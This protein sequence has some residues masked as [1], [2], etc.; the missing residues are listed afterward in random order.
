ME[1]D[2]FSAFEDFGVVDSVKIIPSHKSG[3]SKGFGF[4]EMPDEPSDLKAIAALNG[5]EVIGWTI[6]LNQAENTAV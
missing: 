4:V 3:R 2:L 6:I 5:A 1:V